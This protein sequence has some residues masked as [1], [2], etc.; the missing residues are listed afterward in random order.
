MID[1]TI[2][3]FRQNL[4]WVLLPLV[5]AIAYAWGGAG[6]SS[7]AV[8][9]H[10]DPTAM[11]GV[12]H[13]PHETASDAERN[14]TCSMHPQIRK[15]GPGKCPLCGMD[16]IPVTKANNESEG[17]P[18]RVALSES[19]KIRAQIQTQAVKRLGTGSVERRLL[20]RVDYDETTLRT[21]TA[22]TGG[23]IDRLLVNITGQKIRRGRTIARLYSPEIYSSH[24]DII[25]ARRQLER[26]SGASPSALSASKAALQ[27]SRNRLRLLG[28]PADEVQAMERAKAPSDNVAIRSPFGGTVIERLATEGNYVKTGAGLYKVANLSKLWVQ[29]DAYESDLPLL[30]VGQKVSLTV[31]ALPT[32][33][34][35]GRVA[36]VDPVLNRRTR[37]TRIRIEVNNRN[38]HLRPGMFAEAIVHGATTEAG[39]AQ[40]LVVPATAPLFTGRRSV[41][42]VEVPGTERPTYDARVV[43]LGTRMGEV[44]PVL[45][46]LSEGERV[47]VYGAFTLDA[48]LQIRG[49]AAMMSVSD[50]TEVGPYD[51]GI[52]LPREYRSSLGAVFES[53]LQLHRALSTNDIK[54]GKQS[55]RQMAKATEQLRP[56]SGLTFYD[57]WM[58]I[59]RHIEAHTTHMGH[60]ATL[61][62]LRP[63]FRDLSQQV[64]TLL[65]VFG[66]PLDQSLFLAYCPMALKG[67][68]A[69]WVQGS[70]EIQNPYFGPAMHSCGEVHHSVSHGTYLPV[71]DRAAAGRRTAPAGEHNL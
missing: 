25:Q 20:G 28:V 10:G 1:K 17:G 19:A 33:T 35:K 65:R 66:N 2:Q 16:L 30:A 27:A 8:G 23:R 39:S 60:A 43:R 54:A 47:V 24:Q 37:T 53:Y 59:A 56:A 51:Q 29:L 31:E 48:D 9:Q 46:G 6:A 12:D 5:A 26:L 40:P 45:G 49:G 42:Y 58:P 68:G 18:A 64:A 50:D 11:H 4:P 38:R 32:E 62:E 41:V 69:E 55:A 21:V 34:F 71:S 52:A 14:W 57:A 7:P 67:E 3:R 44:Y 63:P 13:T 61:E 70:K 36:F 15:G 22:W